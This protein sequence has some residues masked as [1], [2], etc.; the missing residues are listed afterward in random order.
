M[1]FIQPYLNE[2]FIPIM[3]YSATLSFAAALSIIVYIRRKTK[4]ITY[5]TIGLVLL[6]ITA[7]LIGINRFF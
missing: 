6:S 3:I 1:R 4:S 2:L 7:S 5:F